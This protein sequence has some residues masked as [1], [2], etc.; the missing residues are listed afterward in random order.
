[1]SHEA[2]SD[3]AV[4]AAAAESEERA[5][6]APYL[7]FT[8]GL[9]LLALAALVAPRAFALSAQERRLLEW[10]DLAVCVVFFADFV[11]TLATSRRRARYFLTWGWLDLL[12]SIP[13]SGAFRWARSGRIVRVLRILRALRAARLLARGLSLRRAESSLA[14]AA[15]LGCG[16]LLS[17]SVAILQVE[18]GDGANIL[19]AEDALWWSL[20]TMTTVGYGD[21][22]PVT[23]EGRVVGAALMILGVGL[24]GVL[25][26][27][28]ASRFVRAEG[29]ESE[30]AQLRR[31]IADIKRLLASNAAAESGTARLAGER[32]P[33]ATG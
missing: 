9:S 11:Y 21:R 26:A 17:S 1:M 32:S 24:F 18:Q 31:E 12:S 3:E 16:M 28:L 4:T 27:F 22:Y 13:A 33:T 15:L 20:S 10:F 7:V 29:G 25:T 2:T 14:T 30:L 23:T 6:S 19:T 8:L 5:R